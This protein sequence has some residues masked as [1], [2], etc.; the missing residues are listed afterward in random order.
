MEAITPNNLVNPGR[1]APSVII[2]EEH[3]IC[4]LVG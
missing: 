1:S 4:L 2:N 3:R